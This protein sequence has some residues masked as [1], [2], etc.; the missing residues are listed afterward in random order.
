MAEEFVMTTSFRNWHLSYRLTTVSWLLGADLHLLMRFTKL[1]LLQKVSGCRQAVQPSLLCLVSTSHPMLPR[2]SPPN[3]HISQL[4]FYS[5]MWHTVVNHCRD[6][7]FYFN[8]KIAINTTPLLSH[9]LESI[10]S[11]KYTLLLLECLASLTS[12]AK[13]SSPS[14]GFASF[15]QH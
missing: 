12:G 5:Q 2:P 15:N 8:R 3:T 4:P 7:A 14:A 9:T 11:C 6:E 1:C 10:Q 13:S